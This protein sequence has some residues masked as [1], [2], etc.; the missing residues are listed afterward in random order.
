MKSIIMIYKWY[1]S[2]TCDKECSW[3]EDVSWCQIIINHNV[4]DC[5]SI[6]INLIEREE[7][8]YFKEKKED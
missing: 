4:Y 5:N 1:D 3:R 7:E 8:K 2:G 6:K